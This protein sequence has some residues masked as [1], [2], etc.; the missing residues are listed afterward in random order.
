MNIFNYLTLRHSSLLNLFA[1][2]SLLGV[3]A[4]PLI[5]FALLIFDRFEGVAFSFL[6]PLLVPIDIFFL[7]FF[8]NCYGSDL[9]NCCGNYLYSIQVVEFARRRHMFNET[10]K[11]HFFNDILYHWNF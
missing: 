11:F 7:I 6:F 4:V 9:L 8:S 1:S 10:L 3:D 5:V 2:L